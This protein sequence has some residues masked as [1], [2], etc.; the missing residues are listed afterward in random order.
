MKRPE[1]T[2]VVYQGQTLVVYHILPPK[3]SPPDLKSL[4]TDGFR[5]RRIN[6]AESFKLSVQV[7]AAQGGRVQLG[8]DLQ[9]AVG[10]F[11]F[12][13]VL[14]KEFWEVFRCLK[15]TFWMVLR[16]L[17]AVFGCFKVLATDNNQK[18]LNC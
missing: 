8:M 12:F 1:K 17:K 5:G 7:V 10:V 3:R 6:E 9:R 2:L 11:F 15:P 16:Y 18:P 14:R 4:E 13:K